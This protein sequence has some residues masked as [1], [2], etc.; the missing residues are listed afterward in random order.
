VGASNG[1]TRMPPLGSSEIDVNAVALLTAWITQSLPER[2]SYTE[3]RLALFGSDTSPAGESTADPDGDG[4]TNSAEYLA[5]TAPLDGSSLLKPTIDVKAGLVSVSVD[6][7]E[8]RIFY[9]ETSTDLTTW[10]NWDVTGNNGM[11]V[12]AGRVELS[13][14]WLGERR[15][16]RLKLSDN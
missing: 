4:A 6:V 11:A 1:F 8:N 7:P 2:E 10:T 12:R 16:F 5:G 13:G 14:A 15:F 3:W 9:V